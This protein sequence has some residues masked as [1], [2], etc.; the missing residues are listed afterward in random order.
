VTKN[1]GVHQEFPGLVRAIQDLIPI[2]FVIAAE[3]ILSLIGPGLDIL[4]TMSL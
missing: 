3:R 2:S 1:S 4:G